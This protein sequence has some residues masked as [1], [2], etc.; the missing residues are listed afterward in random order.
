MWEGGRLQ[1]AIDPRVFVGVE[2]VFDAI[3][4]LHSGRS[5][6]K[7][8]VQLPEKLPPAGGAPPKARL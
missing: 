8:V 4:H 1:V 6:G 2:S 3:D 7:V 5:V